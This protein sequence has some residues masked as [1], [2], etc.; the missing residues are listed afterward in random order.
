MP[1]ALTGARIFDGSRFL[2]G[3][4]AILD[5]DRIGALVREGDLP[6]GLSRERIEGLLA[7]G[8]VD[9]QVNGG[10]GVLFN[11]VRT[12]EGIRAIA[13]AHRRFGTTGCLP[14]FI[15]DS[16][17]R[18]AEAVA[19]MREALR[20]RIPGVLGIHCE[21]PF[22]NPARKGVHDP[23]HMRPIEEEDLRILTSL[24]GGRTLVT[25]APEQVPMSAIRRLAR[26]GVLVCAGHSTAGAATVEE[27]F[28]NG[29]TG[30]THLFNAMPPMAGREPGP[31]GA[32]LA[33]PDSFCG[34]IN[35][36]H[37]VDDVSLR[38][39]IRAKG[40][41]R[42][43]LVSDAMPSVG[44]DLTAFE[45]MGRTVTRADGR[46]TTAEGTLAGCDLDMASAV[47]NTAALGVPLGDALRMASL[48]PAA[49]LRLDGELGRIAPGYRASLVLLD[50]RLEVTRTWIDGAALPLSPH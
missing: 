7:P 8:F 17:A 6:A 1:H 44:T 46:L 43:M 36:G 47:R 15:T 25:L 38:V 31:V 27:A 35:D 5:G 33:D 12:P 30:F 24:G 3:H 9:V 20:A 2:D 49:F 16:R 34:L 41:D 14:T 37:H 23:A 45:L 42:I 19:A 50:E 22:I 13:A 40:A 39:A 28:R 32:A 26:A 18:M 48:T 11:D 10:G 29:L 4:A 21:G